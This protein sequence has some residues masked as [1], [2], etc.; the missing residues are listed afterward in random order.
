MCSKIVNVEEAVGVG[1]WDGVG[2]GVWILVCIVAEKWPVSVI[3][4]QTILIYLPGSPS[5]TPFKLLGCNITGEKA[6]IVQK[7]GG[8]PDRHECWA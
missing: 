3:M 4:H 5:R 7:L 6:F 8:R 1:G 2:G